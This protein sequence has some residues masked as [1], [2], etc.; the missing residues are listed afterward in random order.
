ML[1]KEAG[2]IL[3]KP[4]KVGWTCPT[5]AILSKPWRGCMRSGD[6]GYLLTS[7]A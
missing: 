4:D 2:R 1:D 3:K 7:N 5:S 6:T